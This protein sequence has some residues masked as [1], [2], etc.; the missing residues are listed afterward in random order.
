M[1]EADLRGAA[2]DVMAALSEAERSEATIRRYQAVLDRFAAFLAGRGLSSASDQACVDFI[3]GQ[4]GTRL[5]ALRE[6][7]ADRDV[8]VVRCCASLKIPMKAALAVP[9]WG[10]I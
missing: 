8:Y 7:V 6:P 10:C 4:T 9:M 3:A 5:G 1:G 2:H